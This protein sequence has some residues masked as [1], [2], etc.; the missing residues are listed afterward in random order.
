MFFIDRRSTELNESGTELK[1]G[2][3]GSSMSNDGA[4]VDVA[5][6]ADVSVRVSDIT[7]LAGEASMTC[8]V[9]AARAAAFWM[10]SEDLVVGAVVVDLMPAWPR[11]LPRRLIPT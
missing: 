4:C 2:V 7:S 1:Q 6:V 9:R 5:D 3:T 8:W 11:S 10:K